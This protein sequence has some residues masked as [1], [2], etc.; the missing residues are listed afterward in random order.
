MCILILV[1]FLG[2][3]YQ[4]SQRRRLRSADREG[5]ENVYLARSNE[6]FAEPLEWNVLSDEGFFH[7]AYGVINGCTP[8]QHSL[9][10]VTDHFASDWECRELLEATEMSMRNLFHRGGTTSLAPCHKQ[11]QERL[12]VKG[13]LI[14]EYLLSKARLQVMRDYNLTVLYTSGALLTRLMGNP[15]QDKWDVDPNHVYWNAH[16]DKANIPTYDYSALLYLNSHSS[17]LADDSTPATSSQSQLDGFLGGEFEFVDDDVNRVVEPR[18]GRLVTFTSG[19]ENL[20]RVRKVTKGSRYV[21][22][23][24]FT[25]SEKH[26][27][28]ND[29]DDGKPSAAEEQVVAQTPAY[30]CVG[31]RSC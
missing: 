29:D 24:W 2:S 5:K 1:L 6:S 13:A 22:A 17:A 25:C 26:K 20:H 9:R 12:G 23:I 18:V 31:P 15:P 14:F 16:V 3:V 27:Y 11:S 7:H 10:R 4:E 21:L 30:L 19:P 28:V 8:G